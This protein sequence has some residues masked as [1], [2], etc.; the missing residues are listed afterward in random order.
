[1]TRVYLR[2]VSVAAGERWFRQEPRCCS[3][4]ETESRGVCER[5]GDSDI[6]RRKEAFPLVQKSQH[7]NV[8]SKQ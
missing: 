6:L 2:S 4:E 8:N 3:D 1:M 5:E 7:S